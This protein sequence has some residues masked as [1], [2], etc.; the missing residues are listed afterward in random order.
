MAL[1]PLERLRQDVERRSSDDLSP[2]D[3]SDMPG[4]V[5]PLVSAINLHMARFAA[6]A[7]VQSQFL[8]DASHQLR[9]PLSVL[10]T[11]TAYALRETDPQEV[12][13]ALL[14]M[15]EGLDRAVRTTN[16]M[17]A[18]ARAKDASLAEGGFAPEPVD[19]AETANAVIRT[20]LPAARTRQLDVGMDVPPGP[21][22]VLA[23]DWL[24]R[25]AVSNL[26][27]NAIRY[28]PQGGDLTVRVQVGDGT[29]RLVVEDSG[30]ACRP[31]T[32]PA[33]A[34][35]SGGER[36]ARTSPAPAWAWPSSAPLPRSWARSWS[37]RT[38]RRRPACARRWCLPWKTPWMLRRITKIT[39]F[40]R[41]WK[42]PFCTVASAGP[43][44]PRTGRPAGKAGIGPRPINFGDATMQTRLKLRLAAATAL[45]ALTLSLGAAQAAAEP[46][47][48]E[49]I[50]PPSPAAAST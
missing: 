38:G 46:R 30:P 26:V 43:A 7:R 13:T 17:L 41:C 24:L 23:A 44:E 19:L 47:R 37:W 16:Q 31:R 33:P 28:S 25:E 18:L 49:C 15:Q 9:T 22:K 21:V 12:R 48:P 5:L 39:E 14:A 8:D 20:L 2:V 1:R 3:A 10:R 36:R 11:Q 34:C 32:S 42:V 45:G 50:A 27:D 40:E 4:E 6:Q 29:A 35:V